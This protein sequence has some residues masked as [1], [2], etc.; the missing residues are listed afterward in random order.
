MNSLLQLGSRLFRSFEGIRWLEN[1]TGSYEPTY[2]DACRVLQ[3]L[4]ILKLPTEL[5]LEILEHATYWPSWQNSL[6][7]DKYCEASTDTGLGSGGSAHPSVICLDS[8]VLDNR[9]L[10]EIGKQPIKIKEIQFDFFSYD[11]GWTSENTTGKTATIRFPT[12]SVVLHYHVQILHLRTLTFKS[13]GTYHTSSW[14]EVSIMR[15]PKPT[16]QDMSNQTTK[17]HFRHSEAFNE[18]LMPTGWYLVERPASGQHHPQGDEDKFA[19]YLQGNCVSL[20]SQSG[21]WYK[22]VWSASKERCEGNEGAGKGENFLAELQAGDRIIVWARA[23]VR[24]K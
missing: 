21:C 19:W 1:D 7:E 12:V 6:D 17:T 13:A 24:S 10:S 15:P 2:A 9:L 23:K 4:K 3:I 18:W 20:R 8:P 16:A 5:A 22:V 11:Q 14:L